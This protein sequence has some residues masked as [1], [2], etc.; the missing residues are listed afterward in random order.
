MTKKS[1]PESSG[2]W[3]A[4]PG[5]E[6][7]V[8]VSTKAALVRNLANFPFPSRLNDSE[9][10]RIQSIVFDAFHFLKNADEFQAVPASSLDSVGTKIM[11]ERDVLFPSEG[12]KAGLILRTDGKVSCTVNTDDH[13]RISSFA[14]GLGVESASNSVYVIDSELQ[15]H[16]QFAASY[17]FGYLSHSILNCGSGLSVAAKVHLPALSLLK[18]IKNTAA[19]TVGEDCA[20]TA[21]YG[22][23]GA[24]SVSG[25]G[26]IGSSLGSYYIV[27]TKN[28]AGGTELS[29]LMLIQC[30]LQNLIREERNARKVCKAQK[31]AEI[32]NYAYRALALAKASLFIPLRE[33]VEIISG[34]K[35]G[36]DMGLLSGVEISELHALLYRIQEGHLEY[37]LNSGTF[38]F[39]KDIQDSRQKKIERLRALI[40]QEAFEAAEKV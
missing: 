9:S 25:F 31:S 28:S 11:T 6:Q 24:D 32:A 30:V 34:V 10:E 19:N 23:G 15:K 14:S 20:F 8:I 26:G 13:L 21:C 16:I 1:R 5:A 40:L 18:S 39:E 38:T 4:S 7:D 29:Q 37:A 2:A 17:D 12:R 27:S 3:Y 22:A 33:A 36:I 35:F